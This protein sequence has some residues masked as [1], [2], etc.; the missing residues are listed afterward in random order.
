M[1]RAKRKTK[2][3]MS[4]TKK[5]TTDGRVQKQRIHHFDEEHLSSPRKAITF[6]LIITSMNFSSNLPTKSL[7]KFTISSFISIISIFYI[8]I[9]QT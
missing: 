3:S 9:F 8:L 5:P 1:P 6:N 4:G 2:N 7:E